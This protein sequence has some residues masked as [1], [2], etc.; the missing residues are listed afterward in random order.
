MDKITKTTNTN[1]RVSVVCKKCGN[2]KHR[3]LAVFCSNCG[4]KLNHR[5]L[6]D[7]G[8]IKPSS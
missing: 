4:N 7:C 8:V 6:N 5:E 2:P 3:E 1:E